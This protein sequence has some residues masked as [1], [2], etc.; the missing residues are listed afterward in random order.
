VD[1]AIV[2]NITESDLFTVVV[3]LVVVSTVDVSNSEAIVADS[4][5]R[6]RICSARLH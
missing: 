6:R 2:A 5:L 1:L 4:C 3:V